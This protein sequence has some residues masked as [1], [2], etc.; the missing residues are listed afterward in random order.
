MSTLFWKETKLTMTS[1]EIKALRRLLPY[2]GLSSHSD[3]QEIVPGLPD[4]KVV[5][6][7]MD[8]SS[9]DHLIKTLHHT[10]VSLS[11]ANE[12]NSTDVEF[13]VQYEE[14]LTYPIS[15]TLLNMTYN[16]RPSTKYHDLM[17]VIHQRIWL[18]TEGSPIKIRIHPNENQNTVPW[19][20]Y[21][22]IQTFL[23]KTFQPLDEIPLSIYRKLVN[24]ALSTINLTFA[25]HQKTKQAFTKEW[26]DVPKVPSHLNDQVTKTAY[27][28][29]GN[30]FHPPF[31]KQ[32]NKEITTFDPFKFH[33]KSKKSKIINP[34]QNKH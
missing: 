18:P 20:S 4:A 10:G 1:E 16:L 22:I 8:N 19:L 17:Y 21:L 29:E 3:Q 27:Q 11:K 6:K 30:A 31:Q 25:Q 5:V 34:F 23:R 33:S 28:T 7:G 15:I 13:S 12:A 14:S 24:G 26:P 2:W 9:F 32:E